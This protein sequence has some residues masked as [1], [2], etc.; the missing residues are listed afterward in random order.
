ML[1]INPALTAGFNIP[2]CPEKT[3]KAPSHYKRDAVQVPLPVENYVAQMT[4]PS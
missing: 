1:F 3:N 2:F 4:E